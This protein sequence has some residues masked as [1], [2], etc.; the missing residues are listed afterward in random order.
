MQA[1]GVTSILFL[2]G[3]P[4]ANGPGGEPQGRDPHGGNGTPIAYGPGG[5]DPD[6]NWQ[7]LPPSTQVNTYTC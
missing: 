7:G 1:L 6:A 3:A 4:N 2:Q 5:V